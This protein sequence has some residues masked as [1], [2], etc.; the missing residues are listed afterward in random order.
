MRV[1][2]QR[3]SS[4][5][6]SVDGQQVAEIGKGVLL[7]VGFEKGEKEETLPKMAT[8]CLTLRVFE[9]FEGKMNLSVAD[10]GGDVLAVPNFTLAGSTEKGR[11]PSF[12]RAEDP[13]RARELFERFVEDLR[14]SG[15]KVET[16]RFGRRMKVR[17]VNSGPVTFVLELGTGA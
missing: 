10:I 12:D 11:R 8:K 7:L 15:L 5:S 17:L 4:A 9:D 6:V 2:F 13:D 3:V 14:S 16:G 1:V